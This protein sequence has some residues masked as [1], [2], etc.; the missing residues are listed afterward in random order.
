MDRRTSIKLTAAGLGGLA[1]PGTA[2]A[3]RPTSAGSAPGMPAP[4]IVPTNGI[5]M[6][7]YAQGAGVPVVFCHGFPELAFS[8]RHQFHAASKIDRSDGHDRPAR[9]GRAVRL[10]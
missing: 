9:A 10:R 3:Q 7:V 2:L 6:A 5:D 8:W 4:T 1:L